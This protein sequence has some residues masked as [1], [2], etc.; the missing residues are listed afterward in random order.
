MTSRANPASAG[1]AAHARPEAQPRPLAALYHPLVRRLS[2]GLL[3]VL[4][5]CASPPSGFES[6]VPASRLQA[7]TRAAETRDPASIPRLIEMLDSDDPVVRLAAIRSLE[8]ITGTTLGYDYAAPDWQRREAARA[9]QEW[10]TQSQA[11]FQPNA[12]K[13]TGPAGPPR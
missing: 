12:D 7:I 10:H 11:P 1:A 4:A 2:L 5:G 9:W 3:P 8:R 6:P 13:L